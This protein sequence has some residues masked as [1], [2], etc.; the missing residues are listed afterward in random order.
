MDYST[1]SLAGIYTRYVI[2][3]MIHIDVKC[4]KRRDVLLKQ[5]LYTID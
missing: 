2:I 5:A 4:I 1:S 3:Y